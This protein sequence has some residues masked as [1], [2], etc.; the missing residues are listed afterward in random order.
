MYATHHNTTQ[1][2]SMSTVL[3]VSCVCLF[4]SSGTLC[5][6]THV[7]TYVRVHMYTRENI[8]N[9]GSTTAF[10]LSKANWSSIFMNTPVNVIRP[11]ILKGA[12]QDM[13]K[14]H[15]FV[16]GRTEMRVGTST[17]VR[18]ECAGKARRPTPFDGKRLRT[19]IQKLSAWRITRHTYLCTYTHVYVCELSRT[20]NLC[21]LCNSHVMHK[22]QGAASGNDGNRE[23]Q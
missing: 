20:R 21:A 4:L 12:Q 11:M 5:V 1:H 6:P 2:N 10:R 9:A 16:N 18:L 15:E 22:E 13:D 3:Y 17:S 7:C 23:R 8:C 14:G 19:E